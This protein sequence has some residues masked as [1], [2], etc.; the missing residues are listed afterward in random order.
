[1]SVLMSCVLRSRSI[2][3][4]LMSAG[5]V[6]YGPFHTGGVRQ[7]ICLLSMG[8]LCWYPLSR[9]MTGPCPLRWYGHS[10]LSYTGFWMEMD[11]LSISVRLSFDLIHMFLAGRIGSD[12]GLCKRTHVHCHPPLLRE[13]R[14]VRLGP[15]KKL[16][17][18]PN[19]SSSVKGALKGMV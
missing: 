19:W 11:H 15:P 18:G 16:T 3:A 6:L 17:G 5:S 8:S 14:M 13:Q 10:P 1:M 2:P 12:F 4:K 7:W 9:W